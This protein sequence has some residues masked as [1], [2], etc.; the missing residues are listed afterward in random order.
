MRVFRSILLSLGFLFAFTGEAAETTPSEKETIQGGETNAQVSSSEPSRGGSARLKDKLLKPDGQYATI[1]LVQPIDYTTLNFGETAALAIIN[2]FS[3]YGDF[4]VKTVDD[5][6]S[7]LT[8]EEFRKVVLHNKVDL[9][10]IMILKPTNFDMFLFDK[11]NPYQIYAHS[12]ILPEQLQ[13]QLTKEVVEEYSKVILRRMLYAFTQGQT[14]ELPRQEAQPLLSSEVPRWI[15]SAQSFKTVNR[16]ILSK[17]YGSASVG[18]ALAMGSGK[19][20]NSNL[21]GLQAGYRMFSN[22]FVEGHLE[23]FSYNS[24]GVHVKYLASNTDSP[25]RF[26]FGVGGA[27]TMNEHTINYD[28]GNTQGT[29]G[30]YI[31]PSAAIIFPIVDLHFKVEGQAFIGMGGGKMIFALMPGLFFLF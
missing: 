3:K 8:I 30:S 27:I 5:V 29:G 26:S 19:M 6:L 31:V 16:E 22:I 17:F 9:V 12:E 4:P 11:R 2:A 15:A 13:Y 21:V 25:F 1:A 7:A 20:W 18:A 23:F 14:Y 24:L 28:Q 10:L